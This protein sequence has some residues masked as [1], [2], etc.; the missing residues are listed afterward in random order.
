MIQ[1]IGTTFFT[2]THQG[3]YDDIKY[4]LNTLEPNGLNWKPPQK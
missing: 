3:T 4:H 1:K 2:E